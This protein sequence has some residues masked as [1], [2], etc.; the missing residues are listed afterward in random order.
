MPSFMN[1]FTKHLKIP[2]AYW[3]INVSYAAYSDYYIKIRIRNCTINVTN[4]N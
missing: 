1:K 4:K 3:I 2:K